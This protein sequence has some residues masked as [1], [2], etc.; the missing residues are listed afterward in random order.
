MSKHPAVKH[1][2]TFDIRTVFDMTERIR[3]SEQR[4]AGRS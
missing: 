1:G 3:E 2:N 4:R